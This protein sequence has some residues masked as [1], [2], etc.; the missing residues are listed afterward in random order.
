M[1]LGAQVVGAVL[2]EGCGGTRYAQRGE[3]LLQG[4]QRL[5]F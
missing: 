1:V 3:L 4:W 2:I 5:R